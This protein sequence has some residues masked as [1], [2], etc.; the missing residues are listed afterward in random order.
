MVSAYAENEGT[1][2]TGCEGMAKADNLRTLAAQRVREL[3][4]KAS[5]WEQSLDM[6]VGGQTA[7]M[8]M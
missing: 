1:S 3:M 7:D 4:S 6:K 2:E 5:G 8:V